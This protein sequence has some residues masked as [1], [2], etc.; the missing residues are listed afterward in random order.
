MMT[1]VPDSQTFETSS[2]R[3]LHPEVGNA[4]CVPIDLKST[5]QVAYRDRPEVGNAGN[6]S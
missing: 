1:L 5:I 4:G 2:R 3:H 6:V